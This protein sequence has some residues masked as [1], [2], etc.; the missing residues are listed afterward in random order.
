MT[1]R[2]I[3]PTFIKDGVPSSSRFIP[4]AKDQNKLSVDRGSLVSAEESH[5]NYV[6]SGL[7]SAAV[8]GLTVG[9]FKSVDIPTF[10][11]PIA[12]TP[13]RPENLAHA[14]ADYSAHSAAEQK[15]KA[16]RLQEMAIQRGPLHT[17]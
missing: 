9:E 6:A 7:K 13:D 3:H 14:L 11:D 17:E 15:Q 12:E 16:L 4:S 5:A 10:A 2:Q 1:Y 8:F